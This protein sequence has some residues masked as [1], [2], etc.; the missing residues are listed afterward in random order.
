MK[1]MKSWNAHH[2]RY[3]GFIP[4]TTQG[5]ANVRHKMGMGVPYPCPGQGGHPCPF[6]GVAVDV[7]QNTRTCMCHACNHAVGAFLG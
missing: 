3:A 5:W 4:F 2:K 1:Q 6:D 7:D